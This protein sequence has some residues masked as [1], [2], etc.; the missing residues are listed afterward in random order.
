MVKFGPGVPL[1]MVFKTR[2]SPLGAVSTNST[3]SIFNDV[4]FIT[5]DIEEEGTD[6]GKPETVIVLVIPGQ[7]PKNG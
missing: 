5:T 3:S 4:I 6:V 1:N 2:L 7:N